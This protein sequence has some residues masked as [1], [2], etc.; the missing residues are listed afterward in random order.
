M[1]T[2]QAPIA[3]LLLQVIATANNIG[4]AS[5]IAD[6]TNNIGQSFIQ[7]RNII[8]DY[9]WLPH[10]KCTVNLSYQ[11]GSDTLKWAGK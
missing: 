7:N 6:T 4:P 1:I 8:I 5:S 11:I 3:L 2:I 9:H 10:W